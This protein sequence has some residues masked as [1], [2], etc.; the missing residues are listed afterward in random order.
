MIKLLDLLNEVTIPKNTWTTIPTSEVKDYEDE[1]FDLISKA[2]APIGG[3]PNY[4]SADNVSGAEGTAEY[5]VINLDDDPEIDA[6]N[7][8]K[9]KYGGRKF[10]ATGHDGSREAKSKVVNHKADLLKQPGYFVEVSGKIED[11][12]KAK[13]VEPVMDEELVRKVLK[14]KEINWLGDGRYERKIGGK[15]FTKILMGKPKV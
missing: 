5:E 4:K 15:T 9:R 10:T 12:F 13:G 8:S 2:Y 14:G 6:V 11:I 7:V 1:I 3:H